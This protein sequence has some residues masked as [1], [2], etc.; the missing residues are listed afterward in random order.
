MAPS[1]A[2]GIGSKPLIGETIGALLERIARELPD[3]PALISRHQGTRMTYAELD[4][5]PTGSR[6]R[7]WPRGSRRRP[8]RHLGAE[9]RRVGADAVRDREGGHRSSSTSTPPTGRPSWR[10]RSSSPAAGCS[11]ARSRSRR[12]TTSRWSTRSAATS[13][14]SSASCS[15]TRPTGTSCSPGDGTDPEALRKR[16]WACSSTTRST[17]ST[18]AAPRAS[19]RAPRSATTTSSTTGSSSASCCGYT[20]DDRVCIPVPLYHCFGMVMGNLGCVTHGACMVF[21]AAGVRPGRDARG[22]RRRSAARRSTACR[23]CS[24]PSSTTRDFADVRPH[25]AAHRDHGRLAVPG[26]GHAPRR[27]R[28]AH[29]RGDHLLRHDRDVAGVDADDAPTTR[30]SAASSTVGRV[31]PHVE[32][33]I[34]DP[35]TGARRRAASPASCCTRGYS[36]DARLLGRRRAHRRGDRRRRLD[37]HRRPRDDG[38]RG[39]RQHRRPHQGHGHPR[40]RER[41]PARDRGVPLHPPRRRR[42]PGRRRAR[43]SATARSSAP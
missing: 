22:G 23:R 2:S 40:R 26:R 32:I 1:Y 31:H 14:R 42:R 13:R 37:A 4:A 15:S 20:E 41:L 27:R 39:L 10:T 16:S 28:D 21:P 43:T 36:R 11:S 19:P 9:L 30:S 12:R 7:S 5:A 17:S 29:G 3:H 33:K 6:A 34:V 24:S 35:A 8:R 38:R 18:R 25:D